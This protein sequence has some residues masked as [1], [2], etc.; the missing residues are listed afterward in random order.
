M[1]ISS[2]FQLDTSTTDSTD[3]GSCAHIVVTKP[4]ETAT[5]VILQARIEGTA[6]K[7]LCGY[8]FVP[9]RDPKRLPVCPQCK[10]IYDLMRM[11]NENLNEN[12]RD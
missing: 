9:Q 5:A 2:D 4:H 3:P 1:A 7:A 6:V 8:V 10:E 12:P 11:M